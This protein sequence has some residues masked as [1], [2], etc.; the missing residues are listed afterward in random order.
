MNAIFL[1]EKE[2][3]EFIRENFGLNAKIKMASADDS[4]DFEIDEVPYTWDGEVAAFDVNH[5]EALVA[6]LEDTNVYT[7]TFGEVK[8]TSDSLYR[9]RQ[10]IEE[11]TATAEDLN[12]S[13]TIVLEDEIQGEIDSIEIEQYLDD[14]PAG[15]SEDLFKAWMRLKIGRAIRDERHRQCLSIRKLAELS[16]MSKNNVERI[17]C[18]LYNYTIDN[19]TSILRALNLTL[20]DVSEAN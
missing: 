14:E 11:M 12:V 19:L 5:G 2:A 1:T 20:G 3:R 7:I 13:G 8:E 10:I 4:T 16:G 17:E 18:G 9:A 15:T 6:Y